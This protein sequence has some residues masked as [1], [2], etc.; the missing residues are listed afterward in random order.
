MA[1]AAEIGLAV[2][3]FNPGLGAEIGAP[4]AVPGVTAGVAPETAA[5]AALQAWE[6]RGAVVGGAA[7]VVVVEG[8]VVVAGAGGN[9]S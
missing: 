5:H 4:W 8:V 6:L 3:R 7:A 9:Q 1:A 2:V